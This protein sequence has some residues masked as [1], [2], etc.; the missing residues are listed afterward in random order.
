MNVKFL[1]KYV[2]KKRSLKAPLQTV[3]KGHECL[4]MFVAFSMHIFNEIVEI[5]T[6]K[7]IF[8]V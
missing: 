1:S 5:S 7:M 2:I 6:L 4:V 3:D 8:M